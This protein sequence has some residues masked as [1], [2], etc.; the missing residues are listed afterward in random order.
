MQKRAHG[1]RRNRTLS[2]I[3]V[4]WPVGVI[5]S[6]PRSPGNGRLLDVALQPVLS[7]RETPF[8]LMSW[9]LCRHGALVAMLFWPAAG[10]SLYGIALMMGSEGAVER[11]WKAL[12][13]RSTA[14]DAPAVK[15]GICI[16]DDKN[17]RT[18]GLFQRS[19]KMRYC[20]RWLWLLSVR[21]WRLVVSLLVWSVV[22]AHPTNPMNT[23]PMTTIIFI[24]MSFPQMID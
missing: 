15:R 6:R 13:N 8:L 9:K 2:Q 3:R 20:W 10:P 11:L 1:I 5:D 22:V 16:S 18:A 4:V 19:A 21:F 12:H 24:R 17:R 23:I 14:P 7:W